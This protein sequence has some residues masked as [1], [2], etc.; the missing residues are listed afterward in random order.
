[1][2]DPRSAGRG[3]AAVIDFDHY[4]QRSLS[5]SDR[6][7]RDLRKECPVA[8]TEA[9]GGHWVVSRYQEVASAF[10]DWRRSRRPRV[11]PDVSSLSVGNL[12][13]PPLYPEELDP[14]Q[15]HPCGGFSASCFRRERYNACSHASRTG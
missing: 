14:P 8:W 6:A 4:R 13:I 7:W 3:Q 2:T 12:R 1:M 15:W 9:N 11:D 10:K 5:E